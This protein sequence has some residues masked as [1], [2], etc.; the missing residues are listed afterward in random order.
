[1]EQEELGS[2]IRRLTDNSFASLQKRVM[3]LALDQIMLIGVVFFAIVALRS[4][5][6]SFALL[7]SETGAIY[8]AGLSRTVNCKV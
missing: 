1:M 5:L 7:Y 6:A 4:Y 8:G 3:E 2:K